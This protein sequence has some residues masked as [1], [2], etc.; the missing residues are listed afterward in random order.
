MQSFTSYNH[1]NEM[2]DKQQEHER[3]VQEHQI[4]YNKYQEL[5]TDLQNQLSAVASQ[6]LEH[7]VVDKTLSQIPPEKREGRKC[8]KMIGGVLVDKTVDEVII[9]LDEELKAL[10][11]SKE[12]LEKELTNVRKELSEWMTKNKVKIVRQ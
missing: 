9:I 5:L 11:K 6:L 3:K 1:F 8:F 7:S 12:E 2:A 10:T 4:Q